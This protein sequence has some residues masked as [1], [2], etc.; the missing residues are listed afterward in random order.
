MADERGFSPGAVGLAFLSGAL[1][2]AAAALLLAPKTGRETRD[3]LRGYARRA[4]DGVKDLADKAGEALD[5][6]VDRGLDLVQEK[7]SM[8]TEAWDAGRDAMR[9]ERERYSSEK[10]G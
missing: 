2:G 10:N 7:K 8:L 9:R 1:I 6:A 5:R 4:E 3:Q